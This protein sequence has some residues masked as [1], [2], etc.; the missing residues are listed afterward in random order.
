MPVVA[1]PGASGPRSLRRPCQRAGHLPPEFVA[2]F[3]RHLAG[4][5]IVLLD[6]KL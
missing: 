1:F 2:E 3:T 4:H 5:R 6:G